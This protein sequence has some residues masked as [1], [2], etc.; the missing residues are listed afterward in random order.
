M[1]LVLVSHPGW[2]MVFHRNANDLVA[3]VAKNGY[4]TLV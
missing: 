2:A 1:A 3:R 4:H